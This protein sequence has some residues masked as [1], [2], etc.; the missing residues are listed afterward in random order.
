MNRSKFYI[1][2]GTNWS[3]I[4]EIPPAQERKYSVYPTSEARKYN[5]EYEKMTEN[6]TDNTEKN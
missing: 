4:L 6:K 1:D 3:K 2:A 5:F